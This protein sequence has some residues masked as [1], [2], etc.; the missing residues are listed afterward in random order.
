[1]DARGELGRQG[2]AVAEA[3]LRDQH[4]TIV[5]R[6]YRCRAGEIDLVALDGRV[7]V[8]V[9][10]R[11]RRGTR[12]GTALESVDARKQAQVGRVARHFVAARGWHERDARFDVVGIQ[13]DAQPPAVEHVRGAFEL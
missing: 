11:S 4:F 5:A 13:F 1:V 12:A 3:F 7:V 8:F 10:V 2:E 6:N 9:E